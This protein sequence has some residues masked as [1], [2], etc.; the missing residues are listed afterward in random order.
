MSNLDFFNL[1]KKKETNLVL[2]LDVTNKKDF[3]TIL[4]Q[5][6]PYIC[7]LKLHIELFLQ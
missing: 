2:S 7:A 3:F 6:A 4:K 5:C 1:V